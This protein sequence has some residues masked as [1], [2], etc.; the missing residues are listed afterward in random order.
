MQCISQEPHRL[1]PRAPY[2]PL[3]QIPDRADAQP[4][5]S[6]ELLLGQQ[7]LPP[8]H[9]QQRG[10]R[11]RRRR[12]V[13]RFGAHGDSQP[14]PGTSTQI[15][16]AGNSLPSRARLVWWPPPAVTTEPRSRISQGVAGKVPVLVL[17]LPPPILEA[18]PT[19]LARGSLA[20]TR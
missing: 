12:G 2:P 10:E 20:N 13:C 3:F 7:R 16:A 11:Q 14:T 9:P 1:P 19:L 8:T 6:G 4:R 15:A 17:D 5:S 18:E